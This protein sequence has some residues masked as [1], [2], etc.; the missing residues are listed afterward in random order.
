MKDRPS[1]EDGQLESRA[2]DSAN[3]SEEN[4]T[5]N[6]PGT[7]ARRKEGAKGLRSNFNA[8]YNKKH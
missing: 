6:H 8:L 3:I 7:T 4:F 2:N 5:P 1:S